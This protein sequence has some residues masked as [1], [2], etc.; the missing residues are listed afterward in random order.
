M[1]GHDPC[2][3]PEGST[4]PEGCR[5]EACNDVLCEACEGGVMADCVDNVCFTSYLLD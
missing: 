2:I 5:P 3:V 1:A 4:P